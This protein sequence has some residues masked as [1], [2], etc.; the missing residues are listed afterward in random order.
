MKAST[1]LHRCLLAA[2]L[3]AP[4]CATIDPSQELVTARQTYAKATAAGVPAAPGPLLDAQREL[5]AAEHV[6]IY[7]PRSIDERHL[8]YMATRNAQLAMALG[9]AQ[10]HREAADAA[11]AQ[12]SALLE[13]QVADQKVALAQAERDRDAAVA[14]L[15]KVAQ[16]KQNG[17]TVAI[18]LNGSV[19]FAVNES[20]LLPIAQQRLDSVA[21]AIRHIDP[22]QQI[23]IVGHADT[24]G[25]ASYN[26]KLS[27]DRAEAVRNYL[28]TKGV[29]GDRMVITG[30]GEAEPVA[31]NESAEGR[32]NNRRVEIFINRT[33]SAER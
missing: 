18:T 8:S 10:K 4:A 12:Y 20:R 23:V 17:R 15:K 33:Q 21:E 11:K 22:G 24:T 31:S 32:A 6:H 25:D 29:D 2:S 16:V 19:L 5:D 14:R 9:S 3:L 7:N 30:K 13:G 28:L 27:R 26:E 1:T